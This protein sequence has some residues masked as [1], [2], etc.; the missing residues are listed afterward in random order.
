MSNKF[1]YIITSAPYSSSNGTE[2]IDAIL[3]GANF[4]CDVSVIFIGDGVFQLKKGQQQ[5][6]LKD[7]SKTLLA[8]EDFGVDKVYVDQLSLQARGLQNS[9]LFIEVDQLDSNQIA[10]IIAKQQRVFTF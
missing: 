4:D 6:E 10:S 5:G 8:L 2:A 3:M 1:A 9:D 7:T